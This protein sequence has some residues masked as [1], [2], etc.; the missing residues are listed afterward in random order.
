VLSA[1]IQQLIHFALK[2]KGMPIFEY[3]C[4][5]CGK[6][7][8]EL[9]SRGS[10]SKEKCPGCGSAKTE[11]SLSVFACSSGEAGKSGPSCGSG[12]CCGN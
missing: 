6:K 11:R 9:K 10:E 1:I 4:K 2:E 3:V 12:C 8:E 5:A 7:F